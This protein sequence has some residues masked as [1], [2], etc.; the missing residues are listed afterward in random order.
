MTRRLVIRSALLA[1]LALIGLV[2]PLGAAA[3]PAAPPSARGTV[4]RVFAHRVLVGIGE[5]TPYV[6]QDPRF[7]RLGIRHARLDVGWDSMDDR[8][9]SQLVRAWMQ[10]AHARGIVPLVTFDQSRRRGRH[11]ILPSV[12]DFLHE[13]QIFHRRYPWVREFAA[14]NEANFCGEPSCHHVDRV[15]GYWQAIVH[16]C[17]GCQVLAAE[18]LDVPGMIGWVR[19]FVSIAGTEPRY[20]GLHNYLD[21]N[22]FSDSATLALMRTTRGEVWLT[23]TGGLV[24]RRNHSRVTFPQNP[25]HAARVMQY[26]L[27]HLVF[28]NPRIARVYLYEWNAVSRF[29][30]W[31]SAL[32][33]YNQKA[34]P[35]YY[36]L[37]KDLRAI[38]HLVVG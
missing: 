26:L 38:T 9:Q 19:D 16:H 20:W 36:V 10:V 34:R 33:G 29:D 24:N 22:S 4:A 18:V 8:F 5:E 32:I 27:S 25:K 35:A 14:W 15:V 23:E 11:Q 30:S 12:H 6:F 13:F 3:L 21:A 17:P 28:V 1:G 7:Q 31:D 37:V 2:L